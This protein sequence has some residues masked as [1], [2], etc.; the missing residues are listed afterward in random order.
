MGNEDDEADGLRSV[1]VHLSPDAEE[2]IEELLASRK[3]ADVREAQRV[4]LFVYDVSTGAC[5]IPVKAAWPVPVRT[6]VAV[7]GTLVLVCEAT[8]C[9]IRIVDIY[10]ARDM[11]NDLLVW[12]S[13]LGA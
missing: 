3:E 10:A 5:T 9:D 8:L 12:R 7:V 6:F 2:V 13:I 11:A 1:Q 4:C